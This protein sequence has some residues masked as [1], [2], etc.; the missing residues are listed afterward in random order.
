MKTKTLNIDKKI[1]RELA[2]LS[3]YYDGRYKTRVIT[4]KKKQLSKEFCRKKN[5][6]I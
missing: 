4:D 5:K 1:Q 2:K 3:G 6:D